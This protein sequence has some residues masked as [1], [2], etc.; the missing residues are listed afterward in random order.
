MTF[1]T[2]LLTPALALSVALPAALP[3]AAQGLGYSVSADMGIGAQSVPDYPGAEDYKIAPWVILRDLRLSRDGVTSGPKQ[4]FSWGLS[5]DLKGKRDSDDSDKLRG[6]DDVDP[7]LELG[8]KVGYDAGPFRSYAAIRKGVTGH[9]GITGEI[10]AKYTHDVNDRLTLTGLAELQYGDGKFMDAYFG[11]TPAESA[12]SLYRAYDPAGGLKAAQ[13]RIEARYA[14][15]DSNAVMGRI[16]YTKLLN[17]A[18]DSPITA[19]DDQ[20]SVGVGFVHR[21]NFR[22]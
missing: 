18:A 19:N 15:S 3:A 1:S 16:T 14:V 21:F 11:V 2:R 5:A 22:F 20:I 4:G 6:L 10:G 8:V 13:A 17:D 12:R 7:S 9:K